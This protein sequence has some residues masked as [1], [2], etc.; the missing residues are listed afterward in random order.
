MYFNLFI[1]RDNLFNNQGSKI[2][3]SNVF[4][5]FDI[6]SLSF[7]KTFFIYIYIYIYI[8]MYNIYLYIYIYIESTYDQIFTT[9]GN[10]SFSDL[11]RPL[12]KII[13]RYFVEKTR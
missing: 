7:K 10:I 3:K 4:L 5:R 2:N 6:L 8:Y 13:R 1:I 9:R 11:L 12:R